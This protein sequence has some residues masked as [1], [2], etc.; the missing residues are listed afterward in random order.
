MRPSIRVVK[1][2]GSLL[3]WPELPKALAEWIQ[4]QPTSVHLLIAGGGSLAQAIWQASRAFALPDDAAHWLCID[5]LSVTARLLAE[6]V[7]GVQLVSQFDALKERARNAVTGA[8]VCDCNSFL[9]EHE[10]HS[11]GHVLPCDWTVS[12]DSIAARLAEVL[13]ADELVLLKS[14]DA[15]AAAIQ[16]LANIGYVDE[17]FPAFSKSGFQIRFINLRGWWLNNKMAESRCLRD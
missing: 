14:A 6:V 15:P 3:D 17:L 7:S 12:S 8:V 16:D 1:V 5:A 11:H 9:R 4:S 13:P 2:G 10:H